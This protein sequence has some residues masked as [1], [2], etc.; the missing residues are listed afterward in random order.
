MSNNVRNQQE[1]KTFDSLKAHIKEIPI[2]SVLEHLGIELQKVGSNYQGNCPT[3]HPSES[4][5]CFRVNTKGK[6]FLCFSCLAGGDVISLVEEVKRISFKEAVIW[7]IKEYDIKHSVN[8]KYLKDTVLTEEQKKE[9]GRRLL[10]ATYYETSYEWMHE[11]LFK[12]EG[13]EALAYLVNERKYDVETLKKSEFCFFPYSVEIRKYLREKHPNE[14]DLINALPLVGAFRDNFRIAFP[15]RDARGRITGFIKRSIFPKGISVKK[16]DK[17]HENVRWDSTFGLSKRDLFN[18][19]NTKNN[20]TLLIVEGYPDA[21][22]FN[23]LGM[24]NITAVGQGR[25]AESHLI[26]LKHKRVKNVIISFDNDLVGPN[27]TRDAIELLTSESNITPYVLD[28]NLLSPHKDPDEY[29]KANGIEA[30]QSLLKKIE[31]GLIWYSK[32]II[33]NCDMEDEMSKDNAIKKIIEFACSTTDARENAEISNLIL[34]KFKIDKAVL[35]RMMKTQKDSGKIETYKRIKDGEGAGRFFAFIEKATNSYSYYDT[36]ED[37]VFLGVPKD[38]LEN[39]LVSAQQTLPEVLPVLKADFDVTMN[40]RYD[41][42]KEIFNFFVPTKYMLLEKNDKEINSSERFENIERLLVNLIPRTEERLAYINWLAGILQTRQKQQTA[43]VFKGKPGAGKGLMLEHLLKPLFGSRQAIKVEDEQLNASFNP[44]LQN[45]ILIAFNEV[46]HDNRTRNSINSKVKAIITDSEVIINE[47]NIRN[48]TIT[49]H[50]NC[51]FFSN[52]KVPLF[53][54]QADRRFNIVVTGGNLREKEWFKDPD[55]FIKSL[56]K[57]LP[58]FAQFLMNW[59]Y[60]KNKAMTCIDNEEKQLMVGAAMNKFEEFAHHLKTCDFDWFEENLNP[61]ILKKYF[62]G[63]DLRNG[64]I[65]KGSALIMFQD[66]NSN[67]STNSVDFGKKLKLYEIT[68]QRDRKVGG[69]GHYYT[70]K[71]SLP[72]DIDSGIDEVGKSNEKS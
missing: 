67:F 52:E 58:H 17:I 61:I 44:W 18:L 34:H 4:G 29:V 20:D 51:L 46:A 45:A 9:E 23:A 22:Y 70:W 71:P 6:F 66:I 64:R 10:Y 35:N 40:E 38:I 53:I 37:E 24:D 41:L 31:K 63:S 8:L 19:C 54:E 27:N 48:Y 21:V 62:N 47:K 3:G 11:L 65:K 57:E 39:I 56:E 2:E 1:Y 14:S 42:K 15:Y 72:I 26:G 33:N 30:F 49:N 5:T 13:K 55:E 69:G 36:K 25:L 50:V 12:E 28:P 32:Q 68:A 60:D 16:K 7:L 59:D 43:W